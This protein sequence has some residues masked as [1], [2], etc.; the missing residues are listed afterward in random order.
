[1]V[2]VPVNCLPFFVW[3]VTGTVW[4]NG[5]VVPCA[6]A[7]PAPPTSSSAHAVATAAA[8]SLTFMM[9]TPPFPKMGS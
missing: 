6:D 1:M 4:A 2:Y 5:F 9:K 3:P 8:A 7:V